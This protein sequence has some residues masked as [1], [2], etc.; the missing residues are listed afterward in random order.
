MDRAALRKPIKQSIALYFLQICALM[1][2][3][4]NQYCSKYCHCS[5]ETH[6]TQEV[7]ENKAI[8]WQWM[9]IHEVQLT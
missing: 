8:K 1:H 9:L 5:F 2:M 4:K 6:I 7:V 3:L